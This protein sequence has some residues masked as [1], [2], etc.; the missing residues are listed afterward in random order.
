M[1]EVRDADTSHRRTVAESPPHVR[2]VEAD[3][4]D[5]PDIERYASLLF[6]RGPG[7]ETR[8]LGDETALDRLPEGSRLFV[9]AWREQPIEKPDRAGEGLAWDDPGFEPPDRRQ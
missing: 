8:V 6:V 7:G 3:T 1:G 2:V 4:A 9:D 5:L